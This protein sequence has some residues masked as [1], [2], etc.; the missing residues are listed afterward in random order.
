MRGACHETRRIRSVYERLFHG[1]ALRLEWGFA[2]MCSS[3]S[4]RPVCSTTGR[5]VVEHSTAALICVMNSQRISRRSPTNKSGH[6]PAEGWK[7]SSI[8][9]PLHNSSFNRLLS[10]RSTSGFMKV[11]R[12]SCNQKTAPQP[13]PLPTHQAHQTTLEEDCL[14]LALAILHMYY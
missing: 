12:L 7:N 13:L 4:V 11:R 3:P 10:P 9:A 5:R 8:T 14:A 1:Q 2:Y 6:C